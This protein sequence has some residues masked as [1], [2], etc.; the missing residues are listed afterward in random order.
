MGGG[1]QDVSPG[2]AEP[3]AE[4]G[5]EPVPV[6][7]VGAGAGAG[8]DSGYVAVWVF[9]YFYV[10]VGCVEFVEDYLHHR[11]PYDWAVAQ[12]EVLNVWMDGVK[13]GEGFIDDMLRR[14]RNTYQM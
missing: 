9:G 2:D 13:E 1:A 8:V 5:R 4:G 7:G 12:G 14:S 6:Q 3:Y 11:R 10:D